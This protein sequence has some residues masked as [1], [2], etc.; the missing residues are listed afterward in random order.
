[1]IQRD[2]ERDE[3]G[4]VVDIDSASGIHVFTCIDIV[5][6]SVDCTLV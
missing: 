5:Y 6:I 1:M 3:I 2:E 4:G